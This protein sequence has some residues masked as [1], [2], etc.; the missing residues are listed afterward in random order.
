MESFYLLKME[1]ETR[2]YYDEM[3][4]CANGRNG[5]ESISGAEVVT[6]Y[7]W[8]TI[9]NMPLRLEFDIAVTGGT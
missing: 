9:P 6:Y 1:A 5:M 4:I 2:L 7:R 8:K 3:D